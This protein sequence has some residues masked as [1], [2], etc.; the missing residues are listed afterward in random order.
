VSKINDLQLRQSDSASATIARFSR[1]SPGP[2]SDR[3]SVTVE[4]KGFA[5]L[6]RAV[7]H[8]GEVL[9]AVVI[10]RRGQ[11]RDAEASRADH[12]EVRPTAGRRY[13]QA[14]G[15]S[16]A[17]KEI[18]IATSRWAPQQSSREF[19]S[20]VSTTGAGD[21]AVSKYEDV[22]QIQFSSR[23]GAQPIQSGAA[24][25]HPAGL[26][27]ET[28]DRFDGVARPC[29]TGGF[30]R[31]GG[32]RY[33]SA[34][35]VTLTTPRCCPGRRNKRGPERLRSKPHVARHPRSPGV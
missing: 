35:A 14:S 26:R 28:L 6:W 33:A 19:A 16:G 4:R 5:Y 8:E 2:R 34:N 23:P 17:M 12:E 22:A 21:A 25:H 30:S 29:R 27:A 10:A 15:Y 9:E 20:A 7:D 3:F 31:A 32:S 13:R 18:P 1:L 24:S 11:G